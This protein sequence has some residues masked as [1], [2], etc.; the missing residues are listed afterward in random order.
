MDDA[1]RSTF[2]LCLLALSSVCAGLWLAL[3]EA[4]CPKTL[5]QLSS[6]DDALPRVTQRATL[7]QTAQRAKKPRLPLQQ[8]KRGFPLI[9]HAVDQNRFIRTGNR[10]ASRG[11]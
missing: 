3:A 1:S 4:S 11:R 10:L 7:G 2:R 8:G 5:G 9:I 6:A